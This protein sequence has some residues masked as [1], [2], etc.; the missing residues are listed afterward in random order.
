MLSTD[1][2]CLFDRNGLSAYDWA[3]NGYNVYCYD[4]LNTSYEERD[5]GLGK[6][7]FM[8]WDAKN[9]QST[10]TLIE[11]HKNR[12]A[13]V[14]GF[15]PCDDLAASGAK[16]FK[17]KSLIDPEFQQKAM[18]LFYV[19]LGVAETLEVPYVIENPVSVVSSIYRKPDCVFHPYHYGG[20][21]DENDNHPL[22][23]KY[24]APRDAY[25]KKT[26]YWYG[27]GFIMPPRKEVIPEEGYSRQYKLLGGSSDKTKRIRSMS[28]RGIAKAIYLFNKKD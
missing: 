7:Y 12:T 19:A 27:N 16:H 17:N 3:L 15:P 21:L 22:Y 18:S 26:C 25:P 6:I 13:I 11:Y 2:V 1:V 14:L 8:F 9:K 10:E 23:P 24:I 28:P 5:V 20:Y 4:I